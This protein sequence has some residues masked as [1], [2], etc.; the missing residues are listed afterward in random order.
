[1]ATSIEFYRDVFGL[2]LNFE[3]PDWTEFSTEGATLALHKANASP[4]VEGGQNT[5][6]AG[7]FRPGMVVSD[8]DLFHSRVTEQG[9]TCVQ[10]PK[11]VFGARIAQFL[12]PDSLVI[13]VSE[14]RSGT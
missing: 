14:K 4:S 3:T 11:S 1:M 10:N 6:V 8:L 9:V 5:T 7:Q 13:S 12:D 2:P